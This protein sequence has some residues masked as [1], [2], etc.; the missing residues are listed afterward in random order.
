MNVC[1]GATRNK[2]KTAEFCERCKSKSL[3]ATPHSLTR[4][5]QGQVRGNLQE[6][7]EVLHERGTVRN[8][9]PL[10]GSVVERNKNEQTSF[11]RDAKV[12]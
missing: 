8:S 4:R 12:A 2:P 1:P 3:V 10:I 11:L 6:K 9:D 5:I 7:V